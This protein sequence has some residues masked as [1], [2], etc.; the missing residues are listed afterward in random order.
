M[1]P[2]TGDNIFTYV[3]TEI[4]SS[5]LLLMLLVTKRKER[6]TIGKHAK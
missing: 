2:Q 4:V 5:V 1:N 3:L 6:K